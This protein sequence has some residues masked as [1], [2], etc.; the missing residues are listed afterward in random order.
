M[1]IIMKLQQG[2][3]Q[4]AVSRQFKMSQPSVRDLWN[5]FQRT[6][7]VENVKKPGRPT[8][9]TTREKRMLCRDCLKEPFLSAKALY[10]SSN[11]DKK[12]SVWTVRRALRAGGLV[13]RIAAR[14]PFLSKSN[15][16][17]RK[18]WCKDYSAFNAMD[19]N[20]VIYSDECRL[21]MIPTRRRLVRRR[22]GT[23]LQNN[24]VCH[25]MKY[26]G[27]S[28]MVW[29]A[30]KGDGSRVLV[31]CPTKL[32]SSEYQVV[33][34]QGLKELCDTSNTFM[35]DNAPCHKSAS[36]LAYLER[37]K[38]CLLSDWPP[39]SPDLNIIENLWAHLKKKVTERNPRN[40]GELW[41]FAK[42]EWDRIPNDAIH[43]LYNSIPK[44]LKAV[45]HNHGRHCKY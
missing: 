17:K 13:S 31:K 6:G 41:T 42:E 38:V 24:L 36:T 30:I 40:A 5:K 25:T 34:D 9:L 10:V 32:N 45:I 14:K 21:Q 35:Q 39:Q 23:R 16:V 43:N 22:L 7:N 8:K 11:I 15:I 1:A 26:G 20:N 4:R 12:V 19:W 2:E 44:R 37:R 33:L 18:R 29:G 27:Y 28:I 3:T